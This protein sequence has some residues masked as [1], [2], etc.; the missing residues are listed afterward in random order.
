MKEIY[1]NIFS[2]DTL[3]GLTLMD[4]IYNPY[5]N[6]LVSDADGTL[7]C[8][9]LDAG[10][11]IGLPLDELIGK[12]VKWLVDQG[13]YSHSTV[14]ECIENQ[15]V[16]NSLIRVKNGHY[17]FSTTRP[18]FNEHHE[19]IYTVSTTRVDETIAQISEEFEKERRT[20]RKYMRLASYFQQEYLESEAIVAESRKMKEILDYCDYIAYSDS[21]VLLTGESG[22]GKEVIAKYI[23]KNSPRAGN[24][25]LPLNCGAIPEQLI[26]SELFGHERG[27][28]TGAN[29]RHIGLLEMANGGTV[30]LDEIG[31]MPMALQPRLLRF[32]EEGEI[33]RVGGS[34]T[35]KVD[36][37][38]IAATNRDL[39]QMAEEG[40]FRLD[41]FYRLNVLPVKLPPLRERKEDLKALSTLFL[42]RYNR[43]MHRQIQ[44]SDEMKTYIGSYAWPGNIRELRNVIERYVVTGGQ[45]GEAE[46]KS[47]FKMKK[48]PS[49]EKPVLETFVPLAAA[50]RAF[51]D[52]Y[53]ARA[54]KS[55]GGNITKAAEMLGIH[56]SLIYKKMNIHNEH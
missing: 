32:L 38:V 7:V 51:E 47:G 37:R 12:N 22:T 45:S 13:F 30:F 26:E 9:S 54:I 49:E 3:D 2:A 10:N 24:N 14:L 25:F 8:A 15:K 20:Q 4:I 56:R 33:K 31:E 11:D 42:E 16:V 29:A 36:V 1:K 41:L 39:R 5:D 21:T 34:E 46:I 48:G 27:A 28:F 35:I 44:F 23:Y 52:D 17:V 6:L 40:T 55:C 19:L 50:K 43:K 18:I 53:I